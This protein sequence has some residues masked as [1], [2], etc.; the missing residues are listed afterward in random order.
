MPELEIHVWPD[1]GNLDKVEVMLAM[2]AE[3][4]LFAAMPNLKLLQLFG[5]GVDSVLRD[6]AIPRDLPVSRL[7]DPQFANTMS[8]FVLAAILRYHRQLDE[9]ARQQA[10]HVWQRLHVPYAQERTIGIMGLGALGSDL[11]QKLV[12]FGFR[13]VGWSRSAKELPGVEAFSG[14]D[15]LG[16][17]LSRS[18]ILVCLLPLTP[19]TRGVLCASTFAQMPRGSYVINVG[20][21]EHHVIPDIIAA[22]DAGQLAGVTLDVHEHDPEAPPPDSPLWNH[23]RVTITPHIATLSSSTSA[24]PYIAENIRR[25]RAGLPGLNLMNREGGY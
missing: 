2:R 24:A 16:A 17:F 19:Q 13:V 5:A 6:P 8:L 23:P 10:A 12:G 18:E 11:A 9:Y 21:G 25:I 20:R 4:E 22:L 14:A 1:T 15:Q 7:V 3:A